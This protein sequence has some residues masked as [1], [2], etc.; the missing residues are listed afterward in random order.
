MAFRIQSDS[1]PD[2]F[3]GVIAGAPANATLSQLDGIIAWAAVRKLFAPVYDAS[4]RGQPGF[5]PIVLYKMLLLEELYAL[6][7]VQVSVEGGDR[8]SFRRFLG[9]GAA[10]KAPDDTTLVRFRNRLREGGLL[11]KARREIDRQLAAKNLSVRPGSVKVVDATL[12]RAATRPPK[13]DAPKDAE[14]A[15][16][17]ATDAAKEAPAPGPP[18]APAGGVSGDAPAPGP[19]QGGKKPSRIDGE[20]AFGGKKGRLKYGYKMHSA[21]DAE[22]GHVTDF[23]V[24]PANVADT[25]VFERI[26]GGKE[27]GVLADKGY[28]SAKNREALA[29]RGALDGIM[30]RVGK[31]RENTPPGRIE[32]ERNKGL[33]KLRSPSEGIFATLKRW[34][35]L[36][37]AIYR[38]LV[39]M[40]EQVAMAVTVHNTLKSLRLREKRAQ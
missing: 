34:R 30:R 13:D 9:L 35:R 38:G 17:P 11:D 25:T 40:T 20:A 15:G 37:R 2:A 22:T 21:M 18:A 33:S 19:A 26:L 31:K 10:D 8:L 5:D 12:I 4:G 3:D 23:E 16:A 29:R 1:A 7:D 24:T 28:D 27:S 39:K 32:T 36:G 6:S 14:V